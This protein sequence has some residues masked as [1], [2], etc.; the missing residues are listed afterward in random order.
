MKPQSVSTPPRK[1]S[2]RRP[3]TQRQYCD[4]PYCEFLANETLTVS[5]NDPAD[6]TRN[7][8]TACAEVFRI[9]VQH[10]RLAAKHA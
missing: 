8:C 10:G 7:Y 2:R 5:E 4:N 9:G 6:S 3:R 1:P